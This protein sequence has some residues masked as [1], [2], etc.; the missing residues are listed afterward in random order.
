MGEV[1]EDTSAADGG[2][3]NYRPVI[4]PPPMQTGQYNSPSLSRAPFLTIETSTP[5]ATDATA[6]TPASGRSTP[7]GKKTKTPRTPNSRTPNFLTPNFLTPLGSPIRRVLRMTKLDPHDAWLPITASRNGNAYYAAFHTLCACIGFQ[8]LVAP[9]AFTILGWVWGTISL[10]LAF[11]WQLYTM[12]L[13]VSL[14]ESTDSLTRHGRY[15]K[16]FSDTFGEKMTKIFVSF[17]IMYLSGGTCVALIVLGGTTMRTFYQITCGQDCANPKP[18]TAAEWYLVFTCIAVLLSQLPNLN[19]IAGV[20]LIGA[21]T[22][23]GYCSMLWIVSVSKGRIDNVSYDMITYSSDG[24]R[25]FNILNALGL[26]AFAFRGHNLILEIQSTMPS[27]EK[28]PSSV[29]MWRGVKIAQL[30]V[31]MC[32]FPLAIAGYWAYGSKIPAQGGMLPALY[33]F[34]SQDTSPVVLGFISIFIVINCATCFQIYAMQMHDDTESGLVVKFNGPV[35]WWARVLTRFMFAFSCYFFAVAIPFLGSI[36][37]L[38]GAVA[39]PVTYACPCFLWLKIKKPK[40][41]SLNW[42]VNWVLGVLGGFLTIMTMTAGIYVIIN[43]GIKVSFF[44]PQ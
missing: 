30:F 3:G 33:M 40:K 27:S 11:V 22:A 37:G 29:P 12:G 4:A 23:V 6:I 24:I 36:A 26:I 43:T 19:S 34:H 32:V 10:T 38:I 42:W 16:L 41:Y 28:Y 44:K 14:H 7:G 9:V 20:S 13:L 8:A 15:M 31:A 35:P 17:P 21:I 25:Y 1:V 5:A 2:Y 39:L 18:L